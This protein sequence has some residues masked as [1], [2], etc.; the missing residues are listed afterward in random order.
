[1]TAAVLPLA[2][3][4]DYDLAVSEITAFL[5]GLSPVPEAA[6]HDFPPFFNGRNFPAH[7]AYETGDSEEPRGSDRGTMPGVVELNNDFVYP[8]VGTLAER[9]G[10][11]NATVETRKAY[12]GFRKRL[13]DPMQTNDT[14]DGRVRGIVLVSSDTGDYDA[15]GNPRG[16]ELRT[17][18]LLLVR[19]A[20]T[21]V[22]L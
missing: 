9:D 8:S 3:Y 19:R 18:T 4:E 5:L 20:I 14:M 22:Y 16:V 13:F 15:F 7:L 21:R 2:L 6:R 17:E 11:K 12:S 10:Q 1:M